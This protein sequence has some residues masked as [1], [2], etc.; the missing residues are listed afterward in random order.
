MKVK[1]DA[2]DTHPAGFATGQ[3]SPWLA[4]QGCGFG[5]DDVPCEILGQ[6]KQVMIV[7]WAVVWVAAAWFA[8]SDLVGPKEK[9]L[10]EKVAFPYQLKSIQ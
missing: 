8:P 1:R 3:S 10:L 7:G 9:S 4:E 6:E 2:Q 5:K